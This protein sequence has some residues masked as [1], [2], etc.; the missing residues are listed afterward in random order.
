MHRIMPDHEGAGDGS[1][2]PAWQVHQAPVI[3]RWLASDDDLL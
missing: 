2:A 3:P 1:R